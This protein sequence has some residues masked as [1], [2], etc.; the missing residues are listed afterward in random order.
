MNNPEADSQVDDLLKQG[1]EAAR[2]GNTAVARALLEQVVEQDEHNE[3]AWFWLAAIA[4]DIHEKRVCLT[5]VIVINPENKRARQLLARLE[6]SLIDD[7]AAL[8]QDGGGLSK[9]TVFLAIALGAIALVVLIAVILLTR[10][11]DDSSKNQ[12]PPIPTIAGFGS[13]PEA[14]ETMASPATDGQRTPVPDENDGDTSG[15]ALLHTFTPPPPTW[16]PIPTRTPRPE[17]PATL[18]PPPP[19]SIEG[20]IIIR[21]GQ[22]PGDP[23]N[24]P[25]V[26]VAANGSG[27]R[28]VSP[29]VKR[30]H[31]PVLSP[32]SREFAYI[33]YAP[34]TREFLLQLNNIQGTAPRPA[35]SYWTGNPTLQHQNMPAWSPDGDWIAFV[36]Q[37][38]GA[39]TPDLFR[40][41]LG[42][43]DGDPLALERLTDDDAIESWPAWSP[44]GSKL[45]YVADL[46]MLEFNA[47][48]ELRILDLDTETITDLTDNGATLIEAA[49]D[50]SPDGEFI[51]FH[52]SEAG[53]GPQDTDIYRIAAEGGDAE[54]IID[55]D[56]QDIQPRYSPDGEYLVFS[57]NRTGNWDVFI[58]EFA[59]KSMFQLTTSPHTDVAN[60]W[61][62]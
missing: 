1:I 17:T 32:D 48:T 44:D 25:I 59:T 57:S 12:G 14:G 62:P 11:D 2:A 33:M 22:V 30:G 8:L 60:D 41:A 34:G 18:F 5:N 47:P 31:H 10:G 15:V 51:V 35:S 54:K 3:K 61:G 46:S 50:W 7:R 39:P 26:L 19:H 37:G 43:P 4:E 38:L 56:A 16:T 28:T 29:G 6:G 45:V 52:A 42:D 27:Q 53:G 49:P 55:S 58:Y 9:S 24:Q 20:Q 13:T 23:D 21:S 40:I 36:A